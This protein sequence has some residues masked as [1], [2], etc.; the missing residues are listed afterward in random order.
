M[1]VFDLSL[2]FYRK[3]VKHVRPVHVGLH[4]LMSRVVIPL[5]ER[6]TGMQTMPDDPFWFRLE[7]L[8]GK[9][10]TETAD[11]LA[12][13]VQPGMTVLDVG[14]HVGYYARRFARSVG[15][16]GRVFAFEPHPRTFR[17]LTANTQAYPRVQP[18]QAALAEVAG[19][20]EL[21][22]YLMMSASGSLH[23]DE[24]MADL[25]RAQ[26][27][28]QDI[29]PRLREN[30]AVEKYSVETVTVDDFLA[31]QGVDRVDVVKMDIE[32]AEI[33]A[34]RGMRA[35]IQRSP[36][37]VLVMEYNP[38]ALT[39]FGY[40][41]AAALREVLSLGFRRVQVVEPD[42]T[43]RDLTEDAPALDR[44]TGELTTNMGVV[45]LMLTR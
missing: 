3:T 23:Y 2:N 29:A 35:T 30:F 25:Q 45:N 4:W 33:G 22:D 32:G 34:L 7:L 10:E 24:M 12:K 42:G 43:L 16:A 41:P 27:G 19:T 36:G 44:L 5:L 17:V 15:P 38:A 8:T 13:L 6:A 37:L 14:A 1:R 9:H 39:A 28:A 21:Y 31:G 26:V 18:V 11:L 40:Q 20:A